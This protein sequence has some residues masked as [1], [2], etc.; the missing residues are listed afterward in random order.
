MNGM[1]TARECVSRRARSWN[2]VV[3]ENN[4]KIYNDNKLRIVGCFCL[5][6]VDVGMND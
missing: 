5:F 2:A 3:L 1:E 6:C 4:S